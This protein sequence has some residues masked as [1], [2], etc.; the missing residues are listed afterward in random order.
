MKDIKVRELK[1]EYD[2]NFVP[3][4]EYL[5]SMPDLQNAD[6]V[7]IPIDFVGIHGIHLP[8]RI[9]EKCGQTQEVMAEITGLVSLDASNRGI[10]MSRI[11]RTLYKSKDDVF[12]IN[13]IEEV[14]R[15]YQKDLK[16]FD[17]HILMNFKYRMWQ[18]SLVSKKEDGTPEGG[19][20]YYDVTF[21]CNLDV[22]GE[23]KKIM[24]VSFIYSSACPCSTAL[25]EHAALNRGL[26]GIPH[27]QR[28]IAKLSLIF[29]DMIWIEDVIDYC[30]K[31]LITETLVFC[32]REDEQQFAVLNGYQPKFVE[33]AIRLL[34]DELNTHKS[35]SDY[36]VIVSHNESLHN[37]CAV[38]VITK[39]V[40]GSIFNHHV[41]REEWMSLGSV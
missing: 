10:N 34:A 15:N 19:W 27:S 14:L 41:T 29:E 35:I 20:Q 2:V 25:S 11:L 18:D 17:A 40:E 39:G 7:G 26:Y 5:D 4:K 24:H 33:D 23:F 8:L 6:F 1:K 32:K 22:S 16:T 37:H 13:K 3:S 21:D 38:A 28:S 30:R 36:K 31:S 12:D 9:R